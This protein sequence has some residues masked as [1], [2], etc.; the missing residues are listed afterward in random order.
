[1]ERRVI[2]GHQERII[3]ALD[4]RRVNATE[5]QGMMGVSPYI[6]RRE[7]EKLH[8]MGLLNIEKVFTTEAPNIKF[9]SLTEDGTVVSRLLRQIG[10]IIAG[11]TEVDA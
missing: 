5:L 7:C 3:I 11:N 6:V 1:M 9:Y 8:R 4:G 2:D 10:D